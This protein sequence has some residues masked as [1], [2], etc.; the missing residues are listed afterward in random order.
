MTSNRLDRRAVLK[1][2]G[3]TLLASALAGCAGGNASSGGDG[4]SGDDGGSPFD[5]VSDANGY[6]G[7][8]V[9]AT[10]ESAVTVD[11]G[12]NNGYAFGPATLKISPGTTVTWT[13]TGKGGS[14][15]VVAEDG[16]FESAYSAEKGHTFEHTFEGV[17]VF[18]YYCA[19]HRSM[20]MKGVV[21]AVE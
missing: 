13:W 21:Q 7:S 14:H 15:N 2:T 10:G 16:A 9:D 5:Y 6:D 18:D 20:G 11:V 4:G 1:A 8:P 12:S 17:G 3:A 19:P